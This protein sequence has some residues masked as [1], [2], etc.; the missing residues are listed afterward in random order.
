MGRGNLMVKVGFF[1]FSSN[2]EVKNPVN[3]TGYVYNEIIMLGETTVLLPA[4]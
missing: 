4:Q 2:E 1:T 3:E